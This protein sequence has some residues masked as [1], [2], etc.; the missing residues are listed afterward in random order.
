[1][2]LFVVPS[3]NR[4]GTTPANGLGNGGATGGNSLATGAKVPL[5]VAPSRSRTAS[6]PANGMGNGGL[7]SVGEGGLS[8]AGAA[9]FAAILAKAKSTP[10]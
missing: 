10:S 4:T 8:A 7:A 9:G 1:V 5:S 6:V 2:P 3:R